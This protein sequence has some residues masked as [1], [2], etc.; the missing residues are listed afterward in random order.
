MGGFN[1][2]KKS[3]DTTVF[4]KVGL[5]FKKAIDIYCATKQMNLND[6]V[7]TALAK[8]IGYKGEVI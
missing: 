1:P 5:D 3:K 6:L 4:A 8:E 7:R 2:Q